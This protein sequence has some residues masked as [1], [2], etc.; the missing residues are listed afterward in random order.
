MVSQ[1]S[2]ASHTVSV[3][4]SG[5]P[6]SA[7][8]APPSPVQVS[9]MSQGPAA[10]RHSVPA[11]TRQ[12]SAASLQRFSQAGPPRHG[13]PPP[14][15]QEPALQVSAPLQKRPSSHSPFATHATQAGIVLRNGVGI[16]VADGA[17][18]RR[19]GWTERAAPVVVLRRDG[20]R[21]G[22]RHHAGIVG[23]DGIVREGDRGA[24]G[25]PAVDVADVIEHAYAVPEALDPVAAGRDG[26]RCR[27]DGGIRTV[28]ERRCP[29]TAGPCPCPRRCRRRWCCR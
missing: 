21:G 19:V 16:D 5:R 18:T 28:T 20:G 6:P 25:Q 10:G 23:E 26:R 9:A 22:G 12:V 29:T 13:S 3:S 14:G 2:M 17:V 27:H 7:G 8:Q 1:L 4:V 11:G 24:Q 15:T